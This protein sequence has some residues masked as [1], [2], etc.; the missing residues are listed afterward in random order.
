MNLDIYFKPIEKLILKNNSI[1]SFC[2]FYDVNFPDWEEA[3]IVL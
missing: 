1:G 3:D 2:E